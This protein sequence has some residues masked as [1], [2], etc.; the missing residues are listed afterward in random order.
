VGDLH[1]GAAPNIPPDGCFVDELPPSRIL[2]SRLSSDSFAI[3]S[4]PNVENS[5][6][7]IG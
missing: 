2:A 3:A 6:R 4:M 7:M 5:L 1:L